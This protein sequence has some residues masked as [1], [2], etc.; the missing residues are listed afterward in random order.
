LNI[1]IE[2]VHAMFRDG[3]GYVEGLTQMNIYENDTPNEY[4]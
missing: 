4:I 1:E 2:L 3:Q